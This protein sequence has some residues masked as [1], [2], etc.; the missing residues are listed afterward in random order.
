MILAAWEQYRGLEINRKNTKKKKEADEN[1]NIDVSIYNDWA[2]EQFINYIRFSFEKQ[3]MVMATFVTYFKISRNCSKVKTETVWLRKV[4]LNFLIKQ[5][6][7]FSSKP[8]RINSD[9]LREKQEKEKGPFL[10]LEAKI[11]C[12]QWPLESV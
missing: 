5:Y 9:F 6:L 12:Q 3:F 1:C 10:F 7:S 4:N 2:L 11:V 8:T